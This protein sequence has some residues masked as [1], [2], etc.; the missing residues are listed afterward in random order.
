[1]RVL[2]GRCWEAGGAPA[3]WPWVQALRPYL[4]ELD[5]DVLQ[6]RLGSGAADIAQLFPELR[7]L[8]PDLSEPPAPESVG[9]RIRLFDATVAFLDSIARERP[10]V[11][12]FD[13]LHA[14][15]EP[16]LLLLRFVAREIVGTRLLL[17][18]AYRNVDPTLQRRAPDRALRARARAARPS[19]LPRRSSV[20]R[21]RRFHR[22][23][24]ERLARSSSR[25]GDPFRD[26]R[27]SALRR[28]DRAPP[29]LA[30]A[31][32]RADRRPG[33]T[34]RDSGGHRESRRTAYRVVPRAPLTRLGARERVRGR[35]ASAPQLVSAGEVV[36]RPRRSD[37]GAHHRRSPGE[38]EPSAVH[39]RLDSRHPVRGAHHGRGGCS[40]IAR[41]PRRSSTCMPPSSTHISRKSRSISLP[42]GPS[43]PG[44]RSSM[45]GGRRISL[46]HLW[47]SRR[48]RVSTSWR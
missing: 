37:G 26:R 8:L 30:G 34:A 29:R 40:I 32:E 23:R 3:Y 14:A 45:R 39:A 42:P 5:P 10:L 24:R 12:F 20:R 41:R 36:R 7:E 25:G 13:D 31:S 9:A 2:V 47:R 46:R 16:S 48:Q 27:Q 21:R 44:A 18:A 35:R 1:M 28:G 22:Q 38:P 15:D 11:V 43:P 4:R 6:A 17:I 19:H 33:D